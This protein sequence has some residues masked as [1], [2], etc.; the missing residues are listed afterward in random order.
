MRPWN[1]E[2]GR[3]LQ[4]FRYAVRKIQHLVDSSIMTN[5]AYPCRLLYIRGKYFLLQ[6]GCIAL[7][8]MPHESLGCARRDPLGS[9]QRRAIASSINVCA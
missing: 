5:C 3:R 9:R 6:H 4:Q 7:R 8:A 1:N 2:A